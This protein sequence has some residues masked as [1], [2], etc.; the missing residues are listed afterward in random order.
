MHMTTYQEF[1][2]S[3]IGALLEELNCSDE[4]HEELLFVIQNHRLT[5]I[6][7]NQVINALKI[8]RSIK[9]NNLNTALVAPMQS[10]K[11]GTIFVLVNYI[12]PHLGLLNKTSTVVFVTS[13]RDVDLF[14]QNKYNLEKDFYSTTYEKY[15][16]SHIMVKKMDEFF[17]S[18]N[19]TK[20]I[21]ELNST[22]IIRDE[23]QYGSGSE[24]SF[25]TAFFQN[26][27]MTL[28]KIGLLA[29][30]A[31]PYDILDAKLQ[32]YNVELVDGIR[33][34]KYFGITEMLSQGLVE[35]YPK[36][37][38]P[39]EQVVVDGFEVFKLHS[40]IVEYINH[41]NSFDDGLGLIRVSSSSTAILL[42]DEIKSSFDQ[43]IECIAIG[44]DPMC[45]YKIQ[46][47]L[48][49]IK[50]QVLNQSK[51]IVVIVVHAL[52]AGKD[53]KLL[54]EKVRFGIESRNK[55]LANGAQGISG[56]LCG[57]H[58]N[59]SFKLLAS[60][61]LLKHYSSFEMD[62]EVFSDPNW[63]NEL[64]NQKV[65]GLSTHCKLKLN[66]K[67]GIFSPVIDAQIVNLEDIKSGNK[68]LSFLKE[69]DIEKI[70]ETF[71]DSYINNP[72]KHSKFKIPNCTLRVASNYKPTSNRVYKHWNN[73]VGADF[74][75]IFFQK[76][77]YRYGILISNFDTHDHRNELGF[78][79]IKVF[80]SS[81]PSFREMVTYV[82]NDSMYSMETT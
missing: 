24:S 45:D 3:G 67:R 69:S 41:L 23:D 29:V 38:R 77:H 48:E 18:P 68:I 44:S 8:A 80:F 65:R 22:L 28:P 59:R 79:G 1:W 50:K 35:D 33:P 51:R 39:V 7:P 13:M 40:K 60:V 64:Y 57:Y 30:S 55:Q 58:N 56:R 27:R 71:K 9:N 37:F 47:G 49:Y 34:E 54:K 20:L 66:N 15:M 4:L 16:P 78:Q 73:D 25:D 53:L 14:K 70:L 5:E 76:Y 43:D 74:S 19:P 31:T 42:R 72:F 63:Q 61:E 82:E 21:N 10:G 75:N 36:N 6:Y 26:L 2:N 62:P 11:S 81:E 17:K 12:L 52:S 46:F 32:G